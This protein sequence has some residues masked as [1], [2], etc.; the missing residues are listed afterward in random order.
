MR[1]ALVTGA[2]GFIGSHLSTR[3]IAE[4][5]AVRGVDSFTSHYER[6]LKELN[7]AAL[8]SERHFQLEEVDLAQT[9]VSRL[10]DGVEIVFHL[11]ARPGVR[12]SWG[13]FDDYV[14]A[15][16]AATRALLD[17]CAA[18]G[19]RVV[20]ASSS[21]VYGDIAELPAAERAALRPVSPYGAT[22]AMT[23][24]LAGAYAASLGLDTVGLRY[25]TVYGPRQRPDMGLARFIEAANAGEPIRI[26]GDGLQLRDMTYVGD[27]V[28]ATLAAAEHGRPASVYNVASSLPRALL[29]IVRELEAVLGGELQLEHEERKSGDVRNTWGD[30]ARARRELGYEPRTPL[31][32]GL[33]A[34]VAEAARRRAAL[35]VL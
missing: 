23:E 10:L 2:A 16:I 33:E 15:N 22:K 34:Q 21:S 25:F 13:E 14:H 17:A 32:A 20:Y 24:L 35:A 27:A 8:N 1:R 18:S 19:A 11:A 6:P 4:G 9:D 28:A 3:L 7:I 12:D 29:E 31:R 30:I 5:Y 26:Y